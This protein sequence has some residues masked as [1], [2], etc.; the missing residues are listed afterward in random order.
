MPFTWIRVVL[1]GL[2]MAC[3]A[4]ADTVTIVAT[5]DNTLYEQV[6]GALSNGAGEH[7]FAGK[8]ATTNLSR[9]ALL[10]FDL[11]GAI[12]G[13]ST[14]TSA[15]L[16]LNMSRTI[17][18]AQS[19]ALHRVLADWGEGTSDA[20]LEEGGGAAATV[21]DATWEHRFYNT[22]MWTTAGGDF[23]PAPH[24]TAAVVGL[25]PCTWGSTPQMVA[26][27]Q[28]WLDDGQANFGWILIGEESVAGTA[29]RFDS[30]ENP[31][32]ENRPQLTIEYTP[33]QI[34]D[35]NGNGQPDDDDITNGTSA[36]CDAN[37][38][39]D[40][41]QADSDADSV[42]DACDGCPDDA[43][44]TLPGVCGCGV[45]DGDR[46]GDG[47]ADCRDGCPDDPLKTDPGALG[48]GVPEADTDSDGVPDATDRCPGLN[49]NLDTDGDGTAD[50]VDGCPLDAAKTA[51]GTCGCGTPDA[52]R[53]GDGV[54]DCVDSCPDV[55]NADQ[56]DS[57]ADGIADA[58]D[59]CPAIANPD[60]RDSDG[61]GIG[62]ACDNCPVAANASQAD[63]DGDDVGDLCDNCPAGANSDQVDTD[64]DGVGDAC[65]NCP[66]AANRDQLDSDGDGVGDVCDNCPGTGNPDQADANN[67]GVGDYCDDVR[68]CGGCGPLSMAGFGVAFAAYGG[69]LLVRLTTGPPRYRRR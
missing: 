22:V 61:D 55:A 54:A 60:Q 7:I 12:P 4:K 53:D 45:A 51:P 41:C 59:S 30:R 48:C 50:C 2:L 24:A 56:L 43:A 3:A 66:E 17:S 57:D 8:T 29:K 21:G 23:D 9:R 27:V 20:L 49:D 14:V 32:P 35:C 34:V 37:A 11:A 5:R 63:A 68:G 58:C 36:D 10:R 13:G 18:N 42:I 65:D 52:D 26:D 19:V 46:D 31:T 33:P 38:V 39:P 47:V 28:A 6:G 16:R 40:E 44:K 25:G 15:S 69:A 64:A 1:C 67:D 62:D